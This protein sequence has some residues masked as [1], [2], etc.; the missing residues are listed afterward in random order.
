MKSIAGFILFRFINIFSN[1]FLDRN[2]SS[3]NSKTSQTLYQLYLLVRI[4]RVKILTKTWY[5]QKRFRFVAKIYFKHL[6]DPSTPFY[7]GIYIE[8]LCDDIFRFHS[9]YFSPSSFCLSIGNFG[10]C[11]SIGN[12]GFITLTIF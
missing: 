8:I 3:T 1:C 4:S 5:V 10:F 6:F 12:L 9:K 11:A 7:N 2:S